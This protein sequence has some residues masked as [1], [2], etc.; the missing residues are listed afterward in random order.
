[1]DASARSTRP[2]VLGLLLIPLGA[3]PLLARS[4][5]IDPARLADAWR[6]WP[7]ILVGIG[8][9][10]LASRTRFALV[11]LAVSALTIGTIGG[12]AIASGSFWLGAVS[13]CGFGNDTTH[14]LDQAGAFGGS[15]QVRLELDCGSIDFRAG[16]DAGWTIHAGYRGDP[17]KIEAESNRLSVDTPSGGD[18]RQDWTIGV[19]AAQLGALDMTVNAATSTVDLGNA[20]M[21]RLQADANAGDLRVTAGAATIEE[22]D[23]SMNAGRIRADDRRCSDEGQPVGQ[24]RIDGPLRAA[25]GRPPARGRGSADVRDEPGVAWAE[26][27]R[28]HLDPAGDRRRRHDR[29]LG[30]R[31][32][33]GLQPRS[34]GRLLMGNRLY[35]S[36]DDRMIAGV[37][38]GVAEY[39]DLD[40]SLVRIAWALLVF[41]GGFGV[42]LYIV[43]AIVVPEEDFG[44][45]PWTATPGAGPATPGTGAATGDARQQGLP[46]A[47]GRRVPRRL[48]GPARRRS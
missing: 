25:G 6:L 13:G 12:A 15:A 21:S 24:R 8:V 30:R 29:P 23:L 33:R 7:L 48:A 31:Q 3:I 35:R 37:A 28:Q 1:M 19:P 26:P 2:S 38:G 45:D 47:P 9:A 42:L 41:V 36:R 32:R 43:M 4:G 20:T 27:R 10:I 39:F 5:A 11:G 40:P 17:P 16:G 14:E 46:E 18:R 22:L 34:H 44:P